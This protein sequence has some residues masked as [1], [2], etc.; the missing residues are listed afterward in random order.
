MPVLDLSE[1]NIVIAV[2]GAYFLCTR[3]TIYSPSFRRRF[4][5]WVWLPVGEDQASL[6]LGRGS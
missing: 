6:V 1:L 3:V 2:L 4:H 5:C